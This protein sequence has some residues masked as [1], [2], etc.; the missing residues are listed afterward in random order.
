MR[1]GVGTTP[2]PWQVAW[3]P[4][5]ALAVGLASGWATAMP[6]RAAEAIVLKEGVPVRTELDL[7]RGQLAHFVVDVPAD[8]VLLR[9]EITG[10]PLPLDILARWQEPIE[11]PS[12]A[13]L[14]SE[15][16]AFQ[17]R[18]LI[19]R[20]SDPPLDAGTWHVAV[21]YLESPVA[22]VR[23]RP[24][25][26]IPF[27]IQ[28]SIVRAR[29]EGVLQ[30]GERVSGRVVA[31]EGSVRIYAIEV[32]AEA[33]VLRLDLD[34]TNSDL[35][36]LARHG[37]PVIRN[38]DAEETAISPLGRE[39]LV[40]GA[41]AGRP[42]RPGRWYVSVV[43]PIDY[44]TAD[45]TLYVT[46]GGDPPAAVLAIPPVPRPAEPRAAAL[47]AT[48]E[49][50]TE[51][52]AASGTIVREDGLILTSHHCVADVAQNPPDPD[53]V[54]VAVTLDPRQPP[55][56]LFRGRVVAFDKNLDLAL[57]RITSGLYGQA[58]P[59]GY[60]FPVVALGDP[61]R[62]QIGDPVMTL[63][64]PGVGGS[65]GRVSVTLTRGVVSGFE[66]TPIGT[67]LK[68]DAAISP[69]NSGGAALDQAWRLVGVPTFENVDPEFVGRMSYIHPLWLLPAPWRQ[70]IAAGTAAR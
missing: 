25:R 49:V 2:R 47:H 19:S 16:D 45:F 41:Q 7:D 66:R 20:Q 44:G 23:K 38:E 21:G 31:E 15:P 43:H 8:A 61:E 27:T 69:G 65:A 4:V 6:V 36:L 30:P 17:P 54:I 13:E 39:S 22:V 40:I 29:P 62:M 70:M 35:D 51:L 68:T 9:V 56:E 48:V 58:L 12:D 53:P 11:S 26:R 59:A 3:G 1:S 60:R 64:F 42:L 14:S 18:L 67:L 5:V 32:P 57:V 10:S 33:K 34:G 55:V 28:A 24:V 46:L 63:G 52:G 50:A 37:Q